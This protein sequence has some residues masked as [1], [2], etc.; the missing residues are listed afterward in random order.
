MTRASTVTQPISS[1]ANVYTHT[2]TQTDT[3]TQRHTHTH[4]HTH[5]QKNRHTHSRTHILTNKHTHTHTHTPAHTPY[6][7]QVGLFIQ[8]HMFFN[9]ICIV[10]LAILLFFQNVN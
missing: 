10:G 6:P 3:R 7:H 4:T 8:P 5:T 1:R 9:H 2:G